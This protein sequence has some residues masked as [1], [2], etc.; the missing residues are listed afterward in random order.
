MAIGATA[1][2]SSSTRTRIQSVDLLRGAVMAIMAIDHLRDFLHASAYRFSPEDLTQ[3]YGFLFFTRWITHFCAP[4]FVFLAGVSV[5]LS[6]AK[7]GGLA[8]ASRR[9]IT[10]GLWLILLELTVLEFMWTFN[11]HYEMV[12]LQVIWAIGWSM[13]GLA[14]LIWLPRR[15]V[16]AFALAMIALHNLFDRVPPAQF[17]R[18][19]WLWNLLHVPT[20]FRLGHTNVFA[21]YPLIPWVGV[22]AAGYCFGSILRMEERRRRRILVRLGIGL[23]AAFFVLRAINVYGDPQRWAWQRTTTLTV[24]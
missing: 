14:G 22:M 17:G 6:A 12:M 1:A 23:T 20:L 7:W 21:L 3:T 5:Q 18:W 4:V 8:A 13:I 2:Q 16:V 9:L 19:G 11:F 24:I 10:R 15:A